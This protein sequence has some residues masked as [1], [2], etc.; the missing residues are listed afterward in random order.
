VCRLTEQLTDASGL[1]LDPVA[2]TYFLMMASTAHL[3][4]LIDATGL[5]RAELSSALADQSISAAE[6]AAIKLRAT[7]AAQYW[8]AS[9]AQTDKVIRLRPDLAKGL[10][11]MAQ[12]RTGHDKLL[13]TIRTQ[14]RVEGAVTFTA[15][16]ASQLATL[17]LDAHTKLVDESLSVLEQALHER[18]HATENTRNILMLEMALLALLGLAAGVVLTRSVTRPIEHAVNA[19]QAVSLGELSFAIDTGGKDEASSLLKSFSVMQE[20]LRQRQI[21]DGVRLAESESTSLAANEVAQE[22][23]SLVDMATQGDFSKRIDLSG[24]AAFHADL[25][26]KFN[27]LIDTV[28]ETIQEVRV[29]A[30]QL[31]AASNQVSQTSQSLSMS[32]SQQ[33]ANVEQTTA[34]PQEMSASVMQNAQSAADTDAIASLAAKE[35]QDGG[36]AVRQT[37]EAMKSIAAKIAIIDDIAYQTNLLALNAA[38]EAARAGEHG[39]GFAVVAAEVRKLAERSQAAAQEIGRVAASSVDLAEAA[40]TMLSHMV[41]SIQKTGQLVREISGASGEQSEGVAQISAAMGHLSATTQQTASASEELSATAEELSAQATQLQELMG[42][43]LLNEPGVGVHAKQALPSHLPAQAAS[44]CE[45]AP[46]AARG[47]QASRL[48]KA[49]DLD[50]SAFAQF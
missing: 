31:S 1:S 19:A 8:E 30:S 2:E 18:I 43:F 9:I 22:I 32:A 21:Q 41:P 20:G 6:L 10:P 45:V 37:V 26:A 40:G 12:A 38:I 15:A 5:L 25:C 33:A 49:I 23:K 14:V 44:I 36:Q 50:E 4:H 17:A 35:A 28:S 3:P 47:S 7:A 48:G 11:S 16:E 13:S 39:T 24:K 29:A 34:S 27:E 42:F 46:R